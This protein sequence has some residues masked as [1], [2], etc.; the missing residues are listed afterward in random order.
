MEKINETLQDKHLFSQPLTTKTDMLEFVGACLELNKKVIRLI[1]SF[2]FPFSI[3]KIVI[4]LDNESS[5]EPQVPYLL[6]F[7]HKIGFDIA[8]FSPA[9]MSDLSSYIERG[10]F[11]CQRLETIKYDRSFNSL[12]S[13]ASRKTSHKEGFFSKLFG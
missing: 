10:R 5:V 6:G 3:P 1:D 13:V 8:V 7:L 9:G 11:N 12:G 2:D 4:F